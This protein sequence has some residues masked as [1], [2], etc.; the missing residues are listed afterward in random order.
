MKISLNYIRHIQTSACYNHSG[1]VDFVADHR[2]QGF[3]GLY[4]VELGTNAYILHADGT[5][6]EL[7]CTA[8][9]EHAINTLDTI[10]SNDE[11]K[12]YLSGGCNILMYTCNPEG[13]WD[14]TARLFLVIANLCLYKV[15]FDIM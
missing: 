12:D 5:Y 10:L 6:I 2:Y 11:S 14:V 15:K 8:K 13:W 4:D 9:D 3:D 1:K 7:E